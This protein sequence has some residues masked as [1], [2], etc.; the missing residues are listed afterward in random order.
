MTF[1]DSFTVYHRLHPT[2]EQSA[3]TLSVMILSEK[4]RRISARCLEDIV[5]YDYQKAQKALFPD[6]MIK[7]FTETLRLQEEAKIKWNGRVRELLVKVEDLEKASWN[8]TDAV[9]DMGT[10]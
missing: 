5:F 8:R 6:Y 3:F 7:E 4:H 10:A 9:E 1:P 2:T